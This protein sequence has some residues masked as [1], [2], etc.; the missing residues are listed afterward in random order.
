[1]RQSDLKCGLCGK[2]N[3]YFEPGDSREMHHFSLQWL[4]LG[5]ELHRGPRAET[6]ITK[7]ESA[8]IRQDETSEKYQEQACALAGTSIKLN[9][10]ALNALASPAAGS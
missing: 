10:L 4:R 9:R 7:L 6:A 1:M 5:W 8:V 3:I 2:E